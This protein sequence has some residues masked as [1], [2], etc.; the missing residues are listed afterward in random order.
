MVLHVSQQP[1]YAQAQRIAGAQPVVQTGTP[2]Q[3]GNPAG[4]LNR[5][6][7]RHNMRSG[8]RAKHSVHRLA[9]LNTSW[10]AATFTVLVLGITAGVVGLRSGPMDAL[11]I[12]PY[13]L[14]AAVVLFASVSLLGLGKLW[15]RDEGEGLTRR[16]VLAGVG[17][18]VG[19]IAYALSDFLM[20]PMADGLIRDV[21]VSTLPQTLY[22]QRPASPSVTAVMA[23]FA[24]LFAAIRW[25][26]PVDP[27]RRTR[28]SLWSVAVAVV[29]EWGVHQF[30]PIPQPAGMMI[31]GGTAIVVQ[32]S[33][34][35]I[36]PNRVGEGPR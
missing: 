11:A 33:A 7:W 13:G 19:V 24:L 31:A 36:S 28:L 35:W 10:V 14:V 1:S 18:G 9:E 27:L 26:K 20:L 8:L 25:W 6:Q 3:P 29:A 17:A 15:E 2:I 4:K 5:K 32:M 21:D 34:S 30:L 22:E 12:A 23:H 16:I